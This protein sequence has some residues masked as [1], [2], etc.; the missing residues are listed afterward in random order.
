MPLSDDER[1]RYARHL[2]IPELGPEAYER[3]RAARVLVVGCGGLGS[4]VA[5]YLAAAGIGTLG[6]LDADVV[7]LSNLQRQVLYTTADLGRPKAECAAER[8]RA[9]NPGVAAEPHHVRFSAVNGL[10][11]VRAYDITV[12]GVDNFGSRFLLNDACVLARRTLVEAGL[13]RTVGLAITIRGGETACY[14]C[15]F[16][17]PPPPGA[18]PSAAEA[19]VLGSLAGLMGVI[20]ATEV[21]KVV[22]GFGAPL[23]DRLLQ[24]DAGEMRFDEVAIRRDPRC[25]VCG[26]HPTILTLSDAEAVAKPA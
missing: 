12:T 23:Y 6:L 7:E 11:L 2:V 18:V 4:P 25:P 15:L 20:Q 19:G 5:L 14:R 13:L 1:R 22:A 16:P 17:E 26:E 10:D 8:V 21:L 3:I 24:V 9:L